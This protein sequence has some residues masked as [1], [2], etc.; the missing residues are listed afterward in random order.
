MASPPAGD[1]GGSK[2]TLKLKSSAKTVATK[3]PAAASGQAP[4]P[5]AA[6]PA[7]KG[8]D[9]PPAAPKAQG[10]D[11]EKGADPK[12]LMTIAAFVTLLLVGYFAWMTLGQFLEGPMDKTKDAKVPGLTGRVKPPR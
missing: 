3:P 8:K 2:K 11:P 7:G 10:K 4:P 5:A 9:L 6:P 1:A 12:A